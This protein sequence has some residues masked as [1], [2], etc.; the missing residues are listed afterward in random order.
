MNVVIELKYLCNFC[1][2]RLISSTYLC[3]LMYHSVITKKMTRNFSIYLNLLTLL[4][5]LYFKEAGRRIDHESTH[6]SPPHPPF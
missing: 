1:V 6:S 3:N 5:Y 4:M 2:Y